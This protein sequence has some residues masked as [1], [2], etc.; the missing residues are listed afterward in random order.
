MQGQP[1]NHNMPHNLPNKP[2]LE[3]NFNDS[4]QVRKY[5]QV[6]TNQR[7]DYLEASIKRVEVQVE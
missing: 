3:D 4:I 6:K 1:F 7:L 2:I 5:N